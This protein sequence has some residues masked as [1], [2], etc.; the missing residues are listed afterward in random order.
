MLRTQL[1]DSTE[2]VQLPAATASQGKGSFYRYVQWHMEHPVDDQCTSK[3]Q[4]TEE[5]F[6][7]RVTTCG[8]GLTAKESK[9]GRRNRLPMK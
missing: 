8:G 3:Y 5:V 6:D 1:K 7:S 9:C 2:I 4:C